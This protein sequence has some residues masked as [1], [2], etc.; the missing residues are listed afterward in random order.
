MLL[1]DFE[2]CLATGADAGMKSLREPGDTSGSIPRGLRATQPEDWNQSILRSAWFGED[3]CLLAREF[4]SLIDI[5]R[6]I[7]MPEGE[8][9][10]KLVDT[11]IR[12]YLKVSVR[13]RRKPTH[14]R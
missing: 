6:F 2:P 12:K 1:G 10:G 14:C 4:R 13:I 11:R 9:R 7:Q 3:W 8:R 5:F